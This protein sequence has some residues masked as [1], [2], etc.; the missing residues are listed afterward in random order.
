M[1]HALIVSPKDPFANGAR[2]SLKYPDELVTNNFIS[3]LDLTLRRE[4][5]R[6]LIRC[7]FSTDLDKVQ[8]L[9]SSI[10]ILNTTPKKIGRHDKMGIFNAMIIAMICVSLVVSRQG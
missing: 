7:R 6:K 4:Y 9:S 2:Y 5:E 3:Y 10:N 8:H 1:W